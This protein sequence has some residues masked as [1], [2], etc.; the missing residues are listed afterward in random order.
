MI[1]VSSAVP[2]F[3][4][5]ALSSRPPGVSSRRTPGSFDS[6][7]QSCAHAPLRDSAISSGMSAVCRQTDVLVRSVC[8]APALI[9][10]G[11][12]QRLRGLPNELRRAEPDEWSAAFPPLPPVF[13][14][15]CGVQW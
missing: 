12:A 14:H 15:E 1:S 13:A 6:S 4:S 8:S 3:R 2:R 7:C 9:A 10:R 11:I 5:Q